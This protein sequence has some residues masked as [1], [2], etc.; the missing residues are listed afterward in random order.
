M[1]NFEYELPAIITF[2]CRFEGVY[3]LV[4]KDKGKVNVIMDTENHFN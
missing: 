1:I 3:K 2:K 4:S